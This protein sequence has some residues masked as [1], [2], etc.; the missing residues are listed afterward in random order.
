MSIIGGIKGHTRS[1]DP[2]SVG[3]KPDDQGLT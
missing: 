2:G 1:L 3:R